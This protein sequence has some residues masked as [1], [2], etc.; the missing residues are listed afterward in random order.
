LARVIL[1]QFDD[2]KLREWF[3]VE[4]L[5]EEKVRVCWKVLTWILVMV[6]LKWKVEFLWL[7]G[8]VRQICI[9][10]KSPKN[11]CLWKRPRQIW[12]SRK[13]DNYF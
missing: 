1:F 6:F 9:F 13:L 5:G 10:W 11:V 12:N 7:V 2:S 4:G 3:F 8:K